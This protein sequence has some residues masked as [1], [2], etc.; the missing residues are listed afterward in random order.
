MVL[1]HGALSA[2]TVDPFMSGPRTNRFHINGQNLLVLKF[3]S[4]LGICE[5]RVRTL[6]YLLNYHLFILTTGLII[7]GGPRKISPGP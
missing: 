7:E 1:R 4:T 5:I 2:F 6:A 3:W